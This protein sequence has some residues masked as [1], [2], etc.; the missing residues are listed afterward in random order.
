[1]LE[2]VDKVNLILQAEGLCLK[3]VVD[4]MKSLLEYCKSICTNFDHYENKALLV[5]PK[6]FDDIV[7]PIYHC[8]AKRSRTRDKY[9]TETD[10]NDS[11]EHNFTPRE[12]FR[13]QTFLAVCR[14]S[15]VYSQ[16]YGNF[17]F[18]F[19]FDYSNEDLNSI[20]EGARNLVVKYKG[21][22][23]MDM[24]DEIIQFHKYMSLKMDDSY[25]DNVLNI[26][27]KF[28]Q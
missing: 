23:E 4:S 14:R 12:K 25:H 5:F 8:E 16:V 9:F 27:S 3:A 24:E 2:R 10:R 13:S 11:N 26:A 15:T 19:L 28:L 22:L 18:L 17:S 20:I 6:L 1:M 7:S 21:N